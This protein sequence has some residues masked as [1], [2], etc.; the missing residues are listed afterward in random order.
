[1]LTQ[2]QKLEYVYFGGGCF[3]CIEA[4]FQ[5]LNGVSKVTNGYCGGVPEK[6]NYKDVNSGRTEHVEICKIEYNSKS[7][8]FE[9]L[10]EVFFLAHDPSQLNRQGNDVGRQ[11]R[12]IVFYTNEFQK[13]TTEKYIKKL[14]SEKTYTNVVTKIERMERF[15]KAEEY[16]QNYFKTNPHQAYC[17]Y[18][19]NPKINHLREKLSKYYPK[20]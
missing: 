2:D 4:V 15:F 13:E 5:D 7:I 12:S 18:V 20:K 11:Y 6:A 16:H 9:R 8:S 19:I 1:M 10:L 14:V 17:T 3:W